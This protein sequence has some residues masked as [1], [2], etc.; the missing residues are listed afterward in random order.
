VTCD[1][2]GVAISMPMAFLRGQDP[3]LLRVLA[4]EDAVC[5]PWVAPV[6]STHLWYA[7]IERM[8]AGAH[9]VTVRAR[10]EYG[11]EHVAHTVLDAGA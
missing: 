1:I 8:P 9:R 7:D 2:P 11:R 3:F 4:R 10:G 5:K 6:E